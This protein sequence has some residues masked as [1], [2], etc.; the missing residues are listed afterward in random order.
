VALVFAGLRT[1]GYSFV[2]ILLAAIAK[3]QMWITFTARVF[4]GA[5]G[6]GGVGVRDVALF[7]DAQ[8]T[9]LRGA[10][11]V[12]DRSVEQVIDDSKREFISTLRHLDSH[13]TKWS[14]CIR[15]FSSRFLTAASAQSA[16]GV[17][18]DV[19]VVQP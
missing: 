15:R 12:A 3:H 8:R 7:S 10:G 19:A 13:A 2:A 18:S 9:V 1:R 14:A 4:G 5:V 16:S 6:D 11:V 17:G